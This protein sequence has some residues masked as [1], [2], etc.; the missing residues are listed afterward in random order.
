MSTDTQ[1]HTHTQG[2]SSRT[3]KAYIP[4]AHIS[5]HANLLM[6]KWYLMQVYTAAMKSNGA[7]ELALLN[8]WKEHVCYI[9]QK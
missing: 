9:Y 4:I 2:I 7:H 3:H 8:F 6:P 1:T 5:S